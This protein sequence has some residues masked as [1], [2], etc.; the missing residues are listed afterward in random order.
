MP[1]EACRAG[2]IP[3]IPRSTRED[4]EVVTI[5]SY[6]VVV[7]TNVKPILT[8][9]KDDRSSAQLADALEKCRHVTGTS[10]RERVER[11]RMERVYPCIHEE[12]LNRLLGETNHAWS[13]V[14][15]DSERDLHLV[16]THG[17]SRRGIVFRLETEQL[18]KIESRQNVT[19]HHDE[20]RS[21]PGGQEA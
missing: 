17:H 9:R 16:W 8:K 18:P 21:R 14:G 20:R 6:N 3:R 1:L 19:V 13:V 7:T 5:G 10:F 11:H 12:R 2:I 15:Y 4:I